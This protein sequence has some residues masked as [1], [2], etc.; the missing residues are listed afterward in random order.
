VL[1]LAGTTMFR[2]NSSAG[3]SPARE[4]DV[5]SGKDGAF[6]FSSVRE[7]DWILRAEAENIDRGVAF[8]GVRKDIDD[9]RI[10]LEGPVEILGTVVRSD[11]STA[12]MNG[13]NVMLT[14][15]DGVR[16]ATGNTDKV[17]ALRIEDVSPGHYRITAIPRSGGYYVASVMVGDVDAMRQPA[18]LSDSSP[19]LRI[20]LKAG[21]RLS[22]N[23]E[24]GE[25]SKLLLVPQ[26]VSPGD[27]VQVYPCGAGG[28]FELTGIAPGDYYAIA[29]AHFDPPFKAGFEGVRTIMR[30]ATPVRIDEGALTSVHLKAPVDL[31]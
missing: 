1:S 11:G 4:P 3:V 6:E 14:P 16:G 10:H 25:D 17:G 8:V 28:N 9:V 2:L 21:G 26:T 15:M 12:P 29:V 13:I 18:L 27:I 22:G 20:V 24:K 7:G 30:D 19:P 5:S 23:V 31:P